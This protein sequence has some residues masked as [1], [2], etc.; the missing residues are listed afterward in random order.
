MA[1]ARSSIPPHPLEPQVF[2]T[3]SPGRNPIS[4]EPEGRSHPKGCLSEEGEWL[5][6]CVSGVSAW[7]GAPFHNHPR[8]SKMS[9]SWGRGGG[10]TGKLLTREMLQRGRRGP[11]LL[12]S[13]FGSALAGERP[14]CG[15]SE[16]ALGQVQAAGRSLQWRERA[17]GPPSLFRPLT[18]RPRALC[19][20]P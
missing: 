10:E 15:S 13:Y 19:S 1:P 2:L 6:G 11:R 17:R 12:D 20:P 7:A 3:P 8:P 9:A 5:T 4:V 18:V 16:L 14:L